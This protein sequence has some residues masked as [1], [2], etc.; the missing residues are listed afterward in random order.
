M[1]VVVVMVVVYEGGK[2]NV[3]TLGRQGVFGYWRLERCVIVRGT[4]QGRRGE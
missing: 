4:V 1:V 3:K 2:G